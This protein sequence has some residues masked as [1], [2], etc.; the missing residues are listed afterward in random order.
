MKWE[1]EGKVVGGL[2]VG[3]RAIIMIVEAASNHEVDRMIRSIPLWPMLNWKVIPLESVA[4]RA[5][6][7]RETVKQIK[8][9]KK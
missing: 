3:D 4:G 7:E 9:M 8:A 1:K 6:I 2:P 5:E